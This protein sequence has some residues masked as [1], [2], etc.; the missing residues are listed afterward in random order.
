[1]SFIDRISEKV[2]VLA[3]GQVLAEGTLAQVQANSDVIE[4]YLGR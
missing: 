2:T 1:M 3:A 4:K